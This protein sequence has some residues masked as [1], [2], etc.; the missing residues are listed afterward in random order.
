MKH[1]A[2][3][4]TLILFGMRCFTTK[5]HRLDLIQN[6]EFCVEDGFDVEKTHIKVRI[7]A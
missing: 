5:C 4:A 7:A 2:H 3:T 1:S 6:M